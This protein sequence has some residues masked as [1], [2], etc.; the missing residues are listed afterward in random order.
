MTDLARS[1]RVDMNLAVAAFEELTVRPRRRR[2]APVDADQPA[3]RPR[4][5]ELPTRA[6]KDVLM[7]YLLHVDNDGHGSHPTRDTIARAAGLSIRRVKDVRDRLAGDGWLRVTG[8]AKF[9]RSSG[10]WE[11]R[12][13]YLQQIKEGRGWIPMVSV[14]LGKLVDA[15]DAHR[16]AREDERAVDRLPLFK[17]APVTDVNFQ[18]RGRS[19]YATGEKGGHLPQVRGVKDSER[20]HPSFGW[21]T[22]IESPKEN[23]HKDSSSSGDV[24]RAPPPQPAISEAGGAASAEFAEVDD[25][26]SGAFRE[27]LAAAVRRRRPHWDDERV[28]GFL[29]TWWDPATWLGH[30]VEFPSALNLERIEEVI[31]RDWFVNQGVG[32]RVA[33]RPAKVGGSRR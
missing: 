9:D 31:Y 3:P 1:K 5:W 10:I 25:D 13:L 15:I 26:G 4:P 7:C 20:G 19:S 16:T 12:P 33:P 30:A 2:K 6:A 24:E 11:R 22:S 23:N 32:L 18:E 21:G 27:A 8:L 17:T 28:D 14:N 29:R